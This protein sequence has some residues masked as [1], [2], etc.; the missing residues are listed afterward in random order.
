MTHLLGTI[1]SFNASLT[2]AVFDARSADAWVPTKAAENK[3]QFTGH[4]A[5]ILRGLGKGEELT[6]IDV[7]PSSGVAFELEGASGQLD[8]YRVADGIAL[9]APGRSWWRDVDVD[10][11][12]AELLGAAEDA[13]E[14]ENIE[15]ES[16]RLVAVY[17]WLRQVAQAKELAVPSGDAVSFGDSD[18]AIKGGLVIDLAPGRYRV[19]RHEISAPDGRGLVGMFFVRT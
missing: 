16:G 13:T 18:G 6:P 10:A 11:L 15:I 2:V 1:T 4:P 3:A 12:V 19:A 8:V 14:L 7:G 9:V 17:L 5:E